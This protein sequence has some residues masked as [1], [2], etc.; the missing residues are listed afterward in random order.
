MDMTHSPIPG[1]SAEADASDSAGILLVRAG[2]EAAFPTWRE[3]FAA[4]DPRLDVRWWGDPGVPADA[5]RYVL[6]WQ[7]EPGRLASFP[8]LK[9]ICSSAAGV[10]HI[11]RDP[12]WPS[13]LPLVRMGG[14]H[15]AQQMA[16][17][18]GF[19]AL[20]LQTDIKRIVQAQ[21]E[22]R[23]DNFKRSRLISETRVGVMGLGSLGLQAALLLQRMGF[24]TAG[25]SRS[26]KDIPGIESFVG[27]G[28]LGAFLSRTDILVCLL[29]DT[30]DTRHLLDAQ[31]LALLPPGAG[32]INAA[33]GTH[34]VSR[35]LI[36]ALDS[37]A[38][39]GAVLDVFEV[40]PLP[41]DDPFWTHPRILITSHLASWGSI[42]KR[43]RYVAEAISAFERG[44]RLPNLYLPERGY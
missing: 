33:R 9:L 43:A 26:R 6:C 36:A 34:V 28:E 41:P 35:D 29:P 19:A 30:K 27:K 15:I 10:D 23:W 31:T 44:A 1:S 24:Q 4:A 25:W 38:L 2:G 12:S 5:V 7:P 39:S 20:A 18:V 13:H 32:L 16:E 37:G 11:T 22:R 3:A 17:Y 14:D 8:N 40:E 42:P 21:A